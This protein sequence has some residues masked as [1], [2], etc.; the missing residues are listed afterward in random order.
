MSKIEFINKYIEKCDNAINL[1]NS[2]KAKELQKEIIGIF[3]S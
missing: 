2:Q 3:Q 1:N